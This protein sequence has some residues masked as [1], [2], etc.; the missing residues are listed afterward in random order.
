VGE[1]RWQEI[2]ADLV[3][4]IQ[5]G[6]LPV[7]APIPPLSELVEQWKVSASTAQ[8]AVRSLRDTG[9]LQGRPGVDVRVARV[10]A[11]DERR[12]TTDERLAQLEDHL[13]SAQIRLAALEQ[14]QGDT[15]QSVAELRQM[16]AD[17]QALVLNQAVKAGRP[18][19]SVGGATARR[20]SAAG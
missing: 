3:A 8:K 7:G 15:Q 14:D 20:G 11:E 18:R 6:D 17:L 5:T 1:P 13:S 2:R 4:R 9:V 10:P 16:V 12:L 19:P